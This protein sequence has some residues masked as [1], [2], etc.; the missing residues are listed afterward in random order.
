MNLNNL[1]KVISALGIESNSVCFFYSTLRKI[2]K[3]KQA[4]T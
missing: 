2:A 4:Q 3:I 1:H